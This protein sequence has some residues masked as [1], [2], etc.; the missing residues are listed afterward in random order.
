MT[1]GRYFP[2]MR[3]RGVNP[4]DYVPG[5][6]TESEV[7]DLVNNFGYIPVADAFEFE[8]ISTGAPETMGGCSKWAGTYTTGLDKKYVQVFAFDWTSYGLWSTSFTMLS[9]GVYDGNLLN[10]TG[11]TTQRN[12]LFDTLNSGAELINVR[13]FAQCDFD[14]PFGQFFGFL[15]HGVNAGAVANDNYLSGTINEI[16]SIV[17]RRLAVGFG[18][19]NGTAL[20]NTVIANATYIRARSGGFCVQIRGGA[21]VQYNK[22]TVNLN[23]NSN[24]LG[25]FVDLIA[26]SSTATV[27]ENY[28][29]GEVLS[30]GNT[31]GGFFSEIAGVSAGF[32]LENNYVQCDVS[33]GSVVGGFGGITA[34]NANVNVRL[35]YCVGDVTGG[36]NTR[37]FIGSK[38]AASIVTSCYFDSDVAGTTATQAGQFPRTT[39]QMQEGTEDSYI[40]PGGGVDGGSDPNNLMYDGWNPAIWDFGGSTDYPTLI[41]TP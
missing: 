20:R 7:D 25:G 1:L 30:T 28:V 35:N 36:A 29:T 14:S 19:I 23:S 32:I 37:G 27:S 31:I 40:L 22:A 10:Q 24:N 11:F 21:V 5:L 33:G 41:N 16:N 15:A 8:K 26:G 39:P 38:G 18:F 4:C 34:N 12:G 13:L 9:G 3:R 6:Y 17:N 2:M